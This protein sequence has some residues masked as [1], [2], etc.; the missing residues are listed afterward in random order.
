MIGTGIYLEDVET[1]LARI[2]GQAAANIDRTVMWIGG[3]ALAALAVIAL[4]GAVLNISEHRSADAKLKRLARQVVES[5]EQERARLSRELHDGISQMLVSVK[6]LLESALARFERSPTREAAAEAALSTGLGR[7][8]GT[9]REVRRISH[10]L[11]PAMLDDLGLAAAL[12]QLARELDGQGGIEVRFESTANGQPSATPRT[13]LPDPV[14]TVLFRI[15]QEA[16]NNIARHA[17]ATR[18]ALALDNAPNAVRLVVS[19]NGRGFDAQTALSDPASGLGL[20]NMRERLD[21]LG[22][23]LDIHSQ[24]GRTVIAAT[25][26]L[27]LSAPNLQGLSDDH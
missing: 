16:L 1:A 12:E 17:H 11:R 9:L 7:L 8:A 26:P 24:L 4:C 5:Q 22:G 21:T 3:I 15:A 10:A 20:R 18:A 23:T 19:D 14:N 6:L 25:V 27:P 2:D 13:T